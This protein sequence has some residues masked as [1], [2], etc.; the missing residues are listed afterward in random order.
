MV[1]GYLKALFA[2]NIMYTF[3]ITSVKL[4]ILFLYYRIFHASQRF[5]MV[6]Y[7]VMTFVLLSGVSALPVFIFGCWPIN[8]FWDKSVQGGVCTAFNNY[9]YL[10]E[11]A[12]NIFIDVILLILP[13]PMVWKLQ[14]SQAQRL[15][16]MGVFALGCL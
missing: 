7:A 12:I 11:A 15:G 13:M 6:L 14:I 2:C 10:T 3:L 8:F 16:L 1:T 4:S 9:F 5:R